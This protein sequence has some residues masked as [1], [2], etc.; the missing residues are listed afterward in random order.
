MDNLDNLPTLSVLVAVRNAASTIGRTLA[1]IAEQHYPK[2]NLIVWDG[3]SSDSTCAVLSRYSD[4][5]TLLISE[6]DD[7]PPDAY[8][9]LVALATGE[10]VGFLN[11]DDE[12]EPGAL[13]AVADCIVKEPKVDVVTAG[14]ICRT[15]S[16]E[17]KQ[18]VTGYYANESQLALT[19]SC[20]LSDLPTFLLSRFFKR[21][22]LQSLG[23]F[24]SDR[25]LWYYAN[26]REYITRVV[27]GNYSNAIIPKALIGFNPRSDSMSGNPKHYLRIIQEHLLIADALFNRSDL[28]RAEAI[29]VNRWR[30]RQ[31]AFGFWKAA[32]RM[33]ISQAYTFLR[34][35]LQ[36]GGWCWCLVAIRLL[37]EKVLL[38]VGLTLSDG[39][40]SGLHCKP[41]STHSP[42]RLR[43]P[44]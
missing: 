37:A 39:I 29:V 1:S 41:S 27:L 10:Y 3:L 26:D 22:V 19:L 16:R 24:N 9:R 4:I 13:W 14:I 20:I 18:I 6:R 42:L 12:Y 30:T 25:T 32:G 38:R 31:A 7:G 11:A 36:F 17:D 28:S 44:L 35:G 34:Q 40:D 21:K 8:N 5:I 15:R 23:P 43:G 33:K 2:L